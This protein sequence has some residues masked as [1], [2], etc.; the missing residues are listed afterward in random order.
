MSTA[1]SAE[2]QFSTK[3][4]H[5]MS[6]ILW[7]QHP[8]KPELNGTTEHVSRE[9]AAVAVGYGQAS[10]APYKSYVERLNEESKKPRTPQPGGHFATAETKQPLWQKRPRVNLSRTSCSWRQLYPTA[11]PLLDGGPSP[12][13]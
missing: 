11:W 7:I 3:R 12:R 10:H 1:R 2:R 9:L 5:I 8:T 4:D 6:R 13:K